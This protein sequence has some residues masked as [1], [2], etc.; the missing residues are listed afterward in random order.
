MIAGDW[1]ARKRASCRAAEMPCV[2]SGVSPALNRTCTVQ[3]LPKSLMGLPALDLVLG[4]RCIAVIYRYTR[5]YRWSSSTQKL[6]TDRM[7]LIVAGLLFGAIPGLLI[8]LYYRV[9]RRVGEKMRRASDDKATALV[10]A[11]RT[12]E[13]GMTLR[14]RVASNPGA[15]VIP[16]EII[17]DVRTGERS[18]QGTLVEIVSATSIFSF[19]DPSNQ[20]GQRIRE[21]LPKL[22]QQQARILL[23][24]RLNAAWSAEPSSTALLPSSL[25]QLCE[26]LCRV[27]AGWT[28]GPAGDIVRGMAESK[29]PW[30][31][32]K[33][34]AVIAPSLLACDFARM[35]EQIDEV[36]AAGAEVLHV[37]VMD[38]HFVP[39]LS[40]GPPVVK[41][42]RAYTPHGLDVHLMVTDPA[43]YIEQFA[44]AGASSI[45][46]HIEAAPQ[47]AE[48]V[49]RLHA[50]GLGAGITLRPHTPAEA[51]AGIIATVDLVLVMTVEPG[52]GGQHFIPEMLEKISTVR[53]MLR[54]EQRLEV[55]GGINNDTARQCAG[56]GADTF[57]S[58]TDIFRSGDIGRAVR[59]LRL[60][61]SDRE[62]R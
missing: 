56:R 61:V 45:T 47:P 20:L 46:F 27:R 3:G 22:A 55:D 60:A 58:G 39:N 4:E 19:L 42:I 8:L 13:A 24:C 30:P 40:M 54:P 28:L 57:V 21:Q 43:Y 26:G 38:G 44:E 59:E 9:S 31:A 1:S 15:Y 17:T 52:F 6:S 41:S 53:K 50:M 16:Y 29:N 35:G 25:R 32:V 37:D 12:R 18:A 34:R 14:Q 11:L 51:I 2:A 10:R 23:R 48:L 7:I 36:I 5:R 62:Q 33:G 49:E